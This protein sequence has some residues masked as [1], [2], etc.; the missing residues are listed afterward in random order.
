MNREVLNK[1]LK[2]NRTAFNQIKIDLKR[3]Y[4]RLITLQKDAINNLQNTIK[5]LHPNNTIA[6]GYGL[7]RLGKESISSI[8]SLNV[9]DKIDV[10]LKDGSF[11][12]T[13]NEI[14]K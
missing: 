10:Q 9:G 3:D 14:K 2:E 12:A 8:K 13:V 5:L 11:T 7:V 6:R 1:L 4:D